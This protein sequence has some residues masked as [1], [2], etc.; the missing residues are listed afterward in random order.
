[1]Y[2]L[3]YYGEDELFYFVFNPGYLYYK[4]VRFTE[5]F[6]IYLRIRNPIFL[7]DDQR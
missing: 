7:I 5:I 6:E 4:K 3:G 1:M 2:F